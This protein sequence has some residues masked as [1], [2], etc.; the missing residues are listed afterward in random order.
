M[1]VLLFIIGERD[2]KYSSEISG[3]LYQLHCIF[4][5]MEVPVE[6]LSSLVYPMLIIANTERGRALTANYFK[7]LRIVLNWLK[8]LILRKVVLFLQY[9]SIF[10]HDCL[11]IGL[12]LTMIW[13]IFLV[14]QV[15]LNIDV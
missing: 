6:H 2:Y 11:A 3:D 15:T 7:I 14:S 12:I 8:I 10:T 9:L 4:N 5:R 1:L 13:D